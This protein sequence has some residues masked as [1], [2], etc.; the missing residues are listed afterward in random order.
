M[1]KFVE[2]FLNVSC[3]FKNLMIR[4]VHSIDFISLGFAAEF[5]RRES[6]VKFLITQRCKGDKKMFHRVQPQE[7]VEQD[8]VQS[9]NAAEDSAQK[10]KTVSNDR[11]VVSEAPKK[12]NQPAAVSGSESESP[13]PQAAPYH[14]AKKK[15][16]PV[17]ESQPSY[18]SQ[19]YLQISNTKKDEKTMPEQ[20]ATILGEKEQTARASSDSASIYQRGPA[21]ASSSSSSANYSPS[22]YTSPYAQKSSASAP[23]A[24]AAGE[25]RL[26]IG[27]GITMSGEI[28]SCDHLYVEGTV[29]AAL[30]GAKVLEIAESGV[31]YGTVEIDEATIAGRFEGELVVNGRLTIEA[32]GVITGSISYSELQV[33]SG[34]VIDGRMTP[35]SAAKS[36]GK[37]SAREEARP[38]KPS[39]A[40]F[41]DRDAFEAAE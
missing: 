29:E 39:R 3:E 15:D 11:A 31:F 41:E 37:L 30:K 22:V 21:P 10:T 24:E 32:T 35:V 18:K 16:E 20:N 34:A 33:E 6:A 12:Q 4:S 7:R 14:A 26:T 13:R 28:E 38:S 40:L 17:K 1:K 5:L 19:S 27:R 36:S 23:S 2:I 8:K 25:S 9:P